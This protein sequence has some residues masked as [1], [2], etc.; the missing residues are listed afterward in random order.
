MDR[1]Y[2]WVGTDKGLNKVDLHSPNASIIQYTAGD[3][4]G[5]S[6]INTIC[7]DSPMVYVGTPAGLSY[8][9]ETKVYSSDYCR[10]TWL[11]I[12]SSGQSLLRDTNHLGLSYRQNN[13][14]FEF[15]GISYK[16]A[17]NILYRYRM[18]GLDTAWKTTKEAFLD[19]PTLPSGDYELQLT[20]INKFGTISR[21]LSL[22]FGVSTPFWRTVWFVTAVFLG[23][24]SM[25]W[26]F[27]SL[28]I[29]R[30]RRVEKEKERISQRMMELEH[31][32]LQAQMN[33]HFIFN[34]L[35][36]IQQYIF[37]QGRFPG[38]QVHLRILQTDPGQLCTARA[39]PSSLCPT[40]SAICQA[41]S[42]W[43]SSDLRKKW[44]TLLTWTPAWTIMPVSFRRC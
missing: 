38:Q 13:I 34:C 35:N 29:R 6:V 9:D 25:T 3:G 17:G 40:R 30:I 26:L 31:A 32:A 28:R 8:F 41:I 7:V 36:S 19:Y 39:R 33:P 15:V 2:L 22:R 24:L 5:S 14:R 1:D 20:A 4:L 18:L 11:D 23:V 43:K 44:T 16:S 42:R 12:S 21:P 27:V 37:N 10:L